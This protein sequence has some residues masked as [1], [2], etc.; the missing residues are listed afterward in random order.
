[1]FL[2]VGTY[3]MTMIKKKSRPNADKERKSRKWIKEIA[4][5]R[6]LE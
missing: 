4:V 2:D 6:H 1:M 3:M 5:T